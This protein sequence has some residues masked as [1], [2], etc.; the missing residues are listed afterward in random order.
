VPTRLGPRFA[1]E[2]LFL[3]L[4]AVAVGVADLSSEGIVI[5][6]AGAWLLTA[7][8]EWAAST[9]ARWS[10]PMRPGARLPAGAGAPVV[11]EPPPPEA[12]APSTRDA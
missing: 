11:A 12:Q 3:V 1:I 6:M 7:A 10:F 5:V 8:V 4:V 9:R 2:A